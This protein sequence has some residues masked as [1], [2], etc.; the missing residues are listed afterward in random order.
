VVGGEWR[1]ETA[2]YEADPLSA[3]GGTFFN[4]FS[5]FDPPALQVWEAFGEVEIPLLKDLPF[6]QELTLTGAARYSDYNKGAGTAGTTFAY[7]VSGTWAPVRDLRFRANYSKSV[8]VPTLSDL[9]TPP[10]QNFAFLGDPCDVLNINNGT[11]NR[12]TNCAAQGIPAGFV[13]TFART[14]T[15]ELLSQGNPNLNEETG[16]SLT[17]GGVFTPRWVPGLSLTVDYYRIRVNNLI[18][19]LGGQTILNQCYDLPQ[20]NQFCSLIFP[21]QANFEFSQ[22]ALISG[23]VNFA[24]FKADG[25]DFELAYRRTFGNGHRFQF[26]GVA[27]KVLKRTNFTDPVNPS[28]GDRI[29]GELGDPEWAANATVVYGIGK[30]DLRYSMNFVGKQVIGAYE[31]YFPFQGRPPQNADSTAEVFY[32]SALYHA[33]RLNMK[34]ND[35][36]QFYIGVDNIFDYEPRLYRNTFGSTGSAGGSAYDYIGRYFYAGAQID[37]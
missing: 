17:V 14:Q 32:P 37:F 26:R 18:A 29:L 2:F 16:K 1:K 3:S 13:N 25:I 22:P 4:A 31:S 21:R 8:R 6:A 35:R 11:A 7:N 19:V 12:A 5:T 34:V 23:G 28:I 9:F 15:S 10:T 33:A 24:Q 27:T 20:P 36:H 30:F